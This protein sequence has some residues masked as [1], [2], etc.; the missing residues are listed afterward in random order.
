[1]IDVSEKLVSSVMLKIQGATY[2]KRDIITSVA[3]R[4]LNVTNTVH[5]IQRLLLT[6]V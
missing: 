2:Q 3:I 1:M 4:N 6:P 5:A